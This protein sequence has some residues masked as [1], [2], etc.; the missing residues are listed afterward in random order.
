MAFSFSARSIKQ[1]P[2]VRAMQGGGYE[3]VSGI[4]DANDPR[5]NYGAYASA[6]PTHV[7]SM[8]ANEHNALMGERARAKT[9]AFR[10]DADDQGGL[11][12]VVQGIDPTGGSGRSW[13]AMAGALDMFGVDRLQT[14]AAGGKDMGEFNEDPNNPGTFSRGVRSGGFFDRPSMGA[15]Q[16]QN[17]NYLN[18]S[19]I[20]RG[21]RR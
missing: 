3:R 12:K 8:S 14:G 5:E 15:L 17:M 18:T 20:N 2:S 9:Q 4:P 6:S 10:D 21:G 7:G 16:Q 13:D 19:D 11:A 1:R